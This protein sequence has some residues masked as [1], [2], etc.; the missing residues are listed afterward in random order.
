MMFFIGNGMSP[1]LAYERLVDRMGNVTLSQ[2]ENL[3]DLANNAEEFLKLYGYWDMLAQR[4]V[5]GT[6]RF[7]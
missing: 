6:R 7:I 3:R 5:P 1:A 2:D 4:K